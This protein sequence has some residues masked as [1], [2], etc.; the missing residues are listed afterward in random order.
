MLVHQ[1]R[2]C[3]TPVVNQIG[4]MTMWF[5]NQYPKLGRCFMLH[6]FS[7]DYTDKWHL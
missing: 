6:F 2:G 5:P 4:K 7:H 1:T 3:F